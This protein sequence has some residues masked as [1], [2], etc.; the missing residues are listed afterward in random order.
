MNNQ[1]NYLLDTNIILKD[2]DEV[3]E[4]KKNC[5]III[6][7]ITLRELGR[8][9]SLDG[10]L[11]YLARKALRKLDEIKKYG[12]ISEW[13]KLPNNISIHIE[14]NFIEDLKSISYDCNDDLILGCQAY[15]DKW[16]GKTV[17][18][19][20]DL[21]FELKS[22]SLGFSV[23]NYR[24]KSDLYKNVYSGKIEIEVD[25]CIIDKFYSS[26]INLKDI[27][28][29]P[30][31]NQFVIMTSNINP[32]KKAIGIFKNNKIQ[33]LKYQDYN[34]SKLIPR[35]LEQKMAIELL[36]DDSIPLVSLAGVAG[37]SKTLLQ[38]S[39]SLDKIMQNDSKYKKIILVKPPVSL[40][41][42][43]QT[44]FKKGDLFSKYIN[45]LGSITSNLEVLKEDN[46]NRHMN[47]I[48][49]LEGYIDQ[50]LMEICSLEDLLGMSYNNCIILAEE[51][52]LMTKENIFALLTRLGNSRIFINGDL[53]Q[54][55]RMIPKDP[56]D[57]G[58][59]HTIDV[60]KDSVLSGHL[61]LETIQRS[62]FVSE[63]YKVW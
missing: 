44:G 23:E 47:G 20:N 6:S 12:N 14:F 28:I 15:C 8:Q 11:G 49:L 21:E 32:K 59:F 58:L 50:N 40:D 19:T 33:K 7:N 41:K 1:L 3:L 35:N 62:E 56:R 17:L 29:L 55:S 57:M 48:R 42:D 4:T 2:F 36:M 38:L 37:V 24:S 13:I 60:F 27:K 26:E 10:E 22:E 25:D 53:C 46:Y 51:M 18:V 5:G 63:L 16:Y 30:Y 9:K 54:S 31:E 61:K 39:V 43:F 45:T 52:Q 34:P